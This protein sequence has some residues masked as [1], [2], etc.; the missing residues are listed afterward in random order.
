MKEEKIIRTVELRLMPIVLSLTPQV[1][2]TRAKMTQKKAVTNVLP[3]NDHLRPRLDS[4]K[5]APNCSKR[6]V[7]KLIDDDTQAGEKKTY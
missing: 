5:Y 6:D 3:A 7:H 1:E 2:V 4:I